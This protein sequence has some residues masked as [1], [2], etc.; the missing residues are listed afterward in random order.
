[1]SSLTILCPNAHRVKVPT[2]PNMSLQ[3]VLETACTKK[4]FDSSIHALVRNNK[5]LD[6]TCSIRFSGIPNNATIEMVRM[7]DEEIDLKSN[8][9]EEVSVCLQ[10]PSGERLVETFP[11]STTLANVLSNWK[12]KLEEPAEGEEPV[13]VYMR[14]EVVGQTELNNTTL[15]TLGLTSG[16]GLFRFF[17]KQPSVLKNQANVYDMK[18]EKPMPSEDRHV[19]M[20]LEPEPVKVE[21]LIQRDDNADN[22][23]SN[24]IDIETPVAPDTN[25][26][27][28]CGSSR[29]KDG[30]DRKDE[31]FLAHNPKSTTY[32]T[33]TN[34]QMQQQRP[35]S[36]QNASEAIVI[37]VGPHGALI[38]A[39]KDESDSPR[40]QELDDEFFE[41]S[42]DEV[43]ILY[44]EKK[45]DVKRLNE[46]S[47]LMTKQMRE[48][49][50]ED[51]KQNLVS[52]YK[53]GI[54]RI[55]FPSRHVVQGEFSPDTTISDVMSWLSPLLASKEEQFEIYI[56]PPRTVLPREKTLIE[57]NLFPAALVH[58]SSLV[59]KSEP[60]NFLS[61][62]ALSSLSNCTGANL[63]ASKARRARKDNHTLDESSGTVEVNSLD[64]S[65]SRKL[66][67]ELP[68]NRISYKKQASSNNTSGKVPKWFKT[69]KQ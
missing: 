3:A 2:N 4:G 19:P 13:V 15:K 39:V 56:A 65:E 44:K 8:A 35:D 29:K 25:E 7:S 66:E 36:S 48:A 58:F 64:H 17:Y 14:R 60:V 42:L 61:D 49:A 67:N 46:G 34:E 32:S 23:T 59:T 63:Q 18:I 38:F 43:K 28:E 33:S 12:E 37:P 16:K 68:E 31:N 20:R 50:K 40:Y 45:D 53:K 30:D 69:G 55:Q 52:K 54:L 9:V 47:S 27:S 26:S 10:I 57:L 5:R 24:N 41:L 62:E 1:M 21:P 11:T 6:L 22:S 51:E